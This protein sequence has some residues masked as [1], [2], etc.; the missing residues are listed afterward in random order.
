[1]LFLS[2]LEFQANLLSN[3]L[4]C[5]IGDFLKPQQTQLGDYNGSSS[6]LAFHLNNLAINSYSDGFWF[7][8][9]TTDLSISLTITIEN[10]FEDKWVR[11]MVSFK[12]PFF[13]VE[14]RSIEP[15]RLHTFS[16]LKLK[17]G[18][19]KAKRHLFS[20]KSKFIVPQI[21]GWSFEMLAAPL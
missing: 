7:F 11:K 6:P 3:H 5:A 21:C 14:D 17:N 10:W 13:V 9:D 8:Q 12:P 2:K 4:H 16:N 19:S 15:L 18:A 20:S 1:M